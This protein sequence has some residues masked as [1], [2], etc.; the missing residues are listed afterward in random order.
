[1]SDKTNNTS[2][3]LFLEKKHKVTNIVKNKIF[4]VVAILTVVIMSLISLGALELRDITLETIADIFIEAFP[5]YLA[6]TM[7]S[8]N[9]YTKGTYVGKEQDTYVIAGKYYSEQVIKLDGK[10]LTILPVFCREYNDKVL[11]NM[12]EAILHS[13]ALTMKQF[14][15]YDDKAKAPLKIVPYK[16]V[17]NLYGPVVAKAVEKCKKAKI[18]GLNPN[19]LLSNLNNPDGTD[20]GYN[21]K[22]LAKKRTYTYAI[23]YLF[24]MLFMS[25]IAIKS[26]LDWGWIGVFITLFK[27]AFVVLS[28][29]TRYFEG[30]E[31]ITVSVVDHLYRKSD[32]LKEF[33]YWRSLLNLENQVQCDINEPVE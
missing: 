17:K 27:L 21:E 4:D 5:F 12:Q 7:L 18:K 22:E 15:E 10:A 6:A 31:D 24:A 19:V 16:N 1:M 33:D 20:L 29:L 25:L 11:K 23:S 13:A 8:R 26:I 30:Y 9:Y 2:A 32:V 3:D 28:A 14:H